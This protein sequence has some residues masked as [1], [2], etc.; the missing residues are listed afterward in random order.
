LIKYLENSFGEFSLNLVFQANW[1]RLSILKAVH[2]NVEVLF[3]VDDVK[4]KPSSI[5]GV[6]QGDLLGSEL[7]YFL[8][9][10]SSRTLENGEIASHSYDLCIM[11][12]K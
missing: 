1:S 5:I 2:K 9:R 11:R 10:S 4:K 8:Y 7:F 3:E 12:S 6:K